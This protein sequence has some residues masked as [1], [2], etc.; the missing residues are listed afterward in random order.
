MT[1]SNKLLEI[2]KD[3]SINPA[4]F[5]ANRFLISNNREELNQL[6]EKEKRE[7]LSKLWKEIFHA[8]LLSYSNNN[9][10]THLEFFSEQDMMLFWMKWKS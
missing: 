5:K 7:V 4:V 10:W 8:N 2:I 9:I 3:N 6:T 1:P